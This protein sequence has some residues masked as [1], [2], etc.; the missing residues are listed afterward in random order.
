MTK[1]NNGGFCSSPVIAG[2]FPF[3]FCFPCCPFFWGNISLFI[4]CSQE[5]L[6]QMST[7]VVEV[8]QPEDADPFVP[9]QV[10]IT[11]LPCLHQQRPICECVKA[12]R[13]FAATCMTTCAAGLLCFFPPPSFSLQP[14]K[15]CIFH[16]LFYS[17][18][19]ISLAALYLTA[20]QMVLDFEPLCAELQTRKKPEQEAICHVAPPYFLLYIVSIVEFTQLY[21]LRACQELA[22]LT[23]TRWPLPALLHCTY[24]LF[25]FSGFVILC[26]AV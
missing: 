26:C 8:W 20:V 2:A 3:V 22:I 1:H 6:S 4:S 15:M 18:V 11:P 9:L 19:G 21:T 16:F 7:S 25:F 12:K 10:I 13:K 17:Y 5:A 14:R 23:S 24:F